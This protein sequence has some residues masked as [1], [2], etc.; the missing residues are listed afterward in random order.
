[1]IGGDATRWLGDV[2]GSLRRIVVA[3]RVVAVIW[4]GVLV[5][6]AVVL[7]VEI[8]RSWVVFVAWGVMLGWAAFIVASH[9]V[10]PALLHH[11]LVAAIDLAIAIGTLFVPWMAGNTS[12]L[13]FSAGYPL[14][15]IAFV[16]ALSRAEVGVVAGAALLVAAL[17]RRFVIFANPTPG[18]VLSEVMLWVFPTA[19]LVWAAAIIREFAD[20]RRRSGEALAQAEAERARLEERQDV[21]A[22]LHDSVLQTLAL[23]QRQ[24]GDA[25]EV[26]ALAR[27]QE[28]EL[29][30]WLYGAEET[31]EATLR[32]SVQA[33]CAEVEDAYRVAVELVTTG[34]TPMAPPLEA[35]VWA[36]REAL[37]NAAK[38]AGVQAVSVF[39]E[40]T[41]DAARLYVRDRGVGYD[42]TSID[43]D[44]RGVRDSIV[45][46]M[47]RHGGMA[48]IRTKPGG[49]TDV[50][51]E[52]PLTG[53]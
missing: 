42:L 34:D 51:L 36:G 10:R 13:E 17:V 9:V 49:G 5:L 2:E 45:G 48:D 31:A 50:R 53:F 39:A 43:I 22:H 11:P 16:V 18:N 52:M 27:T 8:P 32:S 35:L 19:L 1:M 33:I 28:R 44:R 40:V 14:S 6:G 15:S 12:T 21:A 30:A 25:E 38:H 7:D 46:R 26:V 4:S 23:I 47:D 24:P 37:V 29:R 41:G 20:E 3:Y